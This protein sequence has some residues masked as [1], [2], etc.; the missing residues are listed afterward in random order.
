VVCDR[1]FTVSKI[2]ALLASDRGLIQGDI[3]PHCLQLNSKE[4]KHKLREKALFSLIKSSNLKSEKL[5]NHQ[6]SLELLTLSKERIRFP[7][8]L[9]WLLIKI[10]IFFEEYQEMETSKLGLTQFSGEQRSQ[11]EKLFQ[12]EI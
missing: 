8:F 1:R 3:C 5:P 10:A 9:D 2:R 4:I 6:Q 11:L 7:S 12:K